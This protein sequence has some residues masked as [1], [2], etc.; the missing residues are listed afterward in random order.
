MT[1]SADH[2][3]EGRAAWQRLRDHG[4]KS[5]D[6]WIAVARAL[7][8]GRTEALKSAETNKPVGSRY[9]RLMGIWLVDHGLDDVNNQERYRALLILQNLDAISAWRAGLDEAQRRRHS[10]P[11][12]VWFAW[13]RATAKSE[14][15]REHVKRSAKAW[16][17][18]R[19]IYF[20]QDMIRRAAMAMRT[21]GPDIFRAARVCLEAAIRSE[22]DL[23]ELLSPD[24]IAMSALPRRTDVVSA[25]GHVG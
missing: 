16:R 22:S 15:R 9:N 3:A 25:A 18:G 1:D 10:H 21:C 11:N 14:P 12:S 5:F 23:I 4:R 8:I 13:K 2:V 7:A 17:P 24:A 19:P 6:D 20:N